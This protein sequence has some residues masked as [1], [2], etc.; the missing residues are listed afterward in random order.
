MKT[1][2][3]IMKGIKEEW[4]EKTR[5]SSKMIKMSCPYCFQYYELT[6]LGNM[7]ASP[8]IVY[9]KVLNHIQTQH[10]D[11]IKQEKA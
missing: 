8:S 11:K 3:E 10:P 6:V 1:L 4:T 2:D 5:R 7:S 9:G